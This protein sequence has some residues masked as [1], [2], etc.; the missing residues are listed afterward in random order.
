LTLL[1]G[2]RLLP[3]AGAPT[4]DRRR[5]DVAGAVGMTG[6]LMLLVFTLVEAPE[7]GWASAQTLAGLGGAAAILTRAR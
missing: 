1:A 5:F 7:A 6:G 2:T 4:R 3:D